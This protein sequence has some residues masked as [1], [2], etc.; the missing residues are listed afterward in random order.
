MNRSA[1]DFRHFIDHLRRQGDL[2]D[3]H[4]EVDANLEIGAIT[5][6]VYERRAPAPLFHNIRDSLPGARVLGAPAG[7]RADRARAH[8]RLALHFGLPEHS[9][10]RDIVATLRAAMRAEP[11]A[12]RRLERGPVQ[13]NVWLGEQVE[14]VRTQTN[15]LWVPANAEIVLEGEISLDETALEGPMGEYHGYSFPTGKPQP[16]FHVHA[17]SFRDQPILPICVAGTPPEENHTI[18][19]T[20]ISAQ[21]LDVAQNAGLPV[22]MV[23]CSY[24]A[25]TCWAVLSI[26]VQRLAALGTDAAAFAARV[27]E[28][29]F[30]SHAGHLVPKLILVGNDIDVTEIDQVVWA[31]AT[32][33]HPLHDHFAFPQIRD[34]PMV[35]YL[36]AEDKARGSGGR[37]VINCLY[38]EQFAGQMRA[39]TASFRH[40]YPTALRRRVEERWS[41]YGFADA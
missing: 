6:R 24:E 22:D 37:L 16:L 23:W 14:V 8:S 31:L 36:D 10:P 19:G 40:A 29:V 7:L 15:G 30:G 4:T 9:G 18:W 41:D 33:A 25:A 39:A 1:L 28:T 13:E 11:I 12:P 2:V 38:P 26:D 3:V 5:R 32:R 34:F 21:L 17:L 35:P 20:M 27:A